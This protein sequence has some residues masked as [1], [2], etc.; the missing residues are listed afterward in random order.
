MESW[1]VKDTFFWRSEPFLQ[2][3][4]ARVSWSA[5]DYLRE[6]APPPHLCLFIVWNATAQAAVRHHNV[7]FLPALSSSTLSIS[8]LLTMHFSPVCLCPAAV[9][10]FSSSVLTT[11][12]QSSSVDTAHRRIFRVWTP[13]SSFLGSKQRYSEDSYIEEQHKDNRLVYGKPFVCH[14]FTFKLFTLT[15]NIFCPQSHRL[16]QTW[17]CRL[18]YLSV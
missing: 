3:L 17:V 11:T 7:C 5:N 8:Q 6:C 14:W 15:E 13:T 9:W 2:Q 10:C 1:G 18:N 16:A 12:H 4:A